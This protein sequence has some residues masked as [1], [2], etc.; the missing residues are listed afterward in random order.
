MLKNKLGINNSKKK[1]KRLKRM[2][3]KNK[4][5]INKNDISHM[6][7]IKLLQNYLKVIFKYLIAISLRGYF[8]KSYT[9]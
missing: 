3:L 1:K 6:K 2:I 8:I 9:F 4:T 7:M 5:S